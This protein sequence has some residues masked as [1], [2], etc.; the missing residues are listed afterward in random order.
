MTWM[1]MLHFT[2]LS[3]LSCEMMQKGGFITVTIFECYYWCPLCSTV[4]TWVKIISSYNNSLFYND[5]AM[6]RICSM[7]DVLGQKFHERYDLDLI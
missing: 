1:Y 3:I 6:I 2:K 7:S 5:D 4:N